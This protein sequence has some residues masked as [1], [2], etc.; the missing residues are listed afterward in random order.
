M[1]AQG[2]IT[3]NAAQSERPSEFMSPV[4]QGLQAAF[5]NVNPFT[6][7]KYE[8]GKGGIHAFADVIMN[9]PAPWRMYQDIQKSRKMESGEIDPSEVLFPYNETDAVAKWLGPGFGAAVGNAWA[10]RPMNTKEA[11]SRA[12]AEVTSTVSKEE[13]KGLGLDEKARLYRE[14]LQNDPALLAEFDKA[15]ELQKQKE[16]NYVSWKESVD[17]D[18][19]QYDRLLA[20]LNLLVAQGKLSARDAA[21]ISDAHSTL[22]DQV[23]EN[24]R[25]QLNEGFFGSAIISAAGQVGTVR[26][27]AQLPSI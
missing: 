18:L 11:R 13:G 17:R 3:G 10:S 20:D 4:M 23:I 14:A 25:S 6:G 12:L 22:P 1:A 5:T 7:A 27:G 16:L 15:F 19:T 21:A 26:T 8:E 24:T 9:S 2:L